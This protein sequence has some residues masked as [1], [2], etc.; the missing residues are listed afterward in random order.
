MAPGWE[1]PSSAL[2]AGL[3]L[4]R[5]GGPRSGDWWRFRVA[6]G[7]WQGQAGQRPARGEEGSAVNERDEGCLTPTKEGLT[8]R[9][10]WLGPHFLSVRGQGQNSPPA[11]KKGCADLMRQCTRAAWKA[12]ARCSEGHARDAGVFGSVLVGTCQPVAALLLGL[13]SPCSQR[14]SP[15]CQVL[16]L[17]AQTAPLPPPHPQP[18]PRRTY[19]CSSSSPPLL[20]PPAWYLFPRPPWQ[21]CTW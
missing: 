12:L 15:A 3:P 1:P 6:P 7:A 10:A 8:P 5:R 18:L 11:P 19:H 13:V 16:R 21:V 2:R 9:S 20:Y 17:A 14:L 4:F